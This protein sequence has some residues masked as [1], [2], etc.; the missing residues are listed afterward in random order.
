MAEEG[1][2]VEQQYRQRG[3]IGNRKWLNKIK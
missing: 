2:G 1:I 3:D